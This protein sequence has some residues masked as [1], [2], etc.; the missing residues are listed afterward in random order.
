MAP[1]TIRRFRFGRG[2]REA[3]AGDTLLDALAVDGL[4]NVVRSVRY[5]RPRAPFCGTGDCTGCL[6][7]VNGRPNVRA[8]RHPVEDGDRVEGGNAWPSA[9][10]DALAAVDLLFPHGIDTLRGFRRPAWARGLYHRVI[11]RLAGYSEPPDAAAAAALASPPRT[12]DA[13]TVVVGS[14]TAGTAAAARLVARG[15][16][17]VLLDR[18]RDL[19]AIPGA[20]TV[21]GA[22]VTF[23][24]PPTSDLLRPFT[25]L[26]FEEPGRGL[27]VRCRS[28]VLA[29][30]SYDTQ[31]LFAG[32]DRPGVV[33]AELA[34][35]FARPG[36][37]S[38]L[39]R[40]V[41]VGGAARAG[42]ILD[43]LG[44]T[45]RAV[46]APGEIGP[47]VARKAS[48]HGVPLY[49][50]TLVLAAVGRSRV[51]RLE[52]KGRGD[53]PRFSVPCDAVVLAH[54][55]APAGQLAIQAGALLEWRPDPGAYVPRVTGG[56]AT[57]VPGLFVAGSA[58]GLARSDSPASGERAADAAAAGAA[59]YTGDPGT[60]PVAAGEFEGYYR[61][62]LHERGTGKWFACGCEDVLLEEVERA[63]ADGYRG[64]EVIKRYTGLGTG[65]CQGRYCLPDALLLL[66]ILE[67]RPP[68]DVGRI[69]QRP[70][71]VPTPLAA[72]AALDP[73]ISK[74]RVP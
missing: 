21:G 8:C 50:R 51:R 57:S 22:T 35:R 47:E 36:R 63:S 45:V 37:Q 31:L 4:P 1:R 11:R 24:P 10:L 56:G 12:V 74:Q 72:L 53:G 17:P 15:V 71:A 61:E 23:L 65:L 14:G 41:V 28:V 67:R 25:L 9:R 40:A 3:T 32:N 2:P 34:L 62:L 5:H 27:V 6:V 43:R 29:T 18:R 7:R 26:G 38:P 60:A 19:S 59:P 33:S 30:G 20:D 70:P 13:E 66:S 68:T 58:G 69:T 46:V 42:E 64:I 55:R 54:R 73:E 49:P 16:R 52:L 44:D 39:R 48:D